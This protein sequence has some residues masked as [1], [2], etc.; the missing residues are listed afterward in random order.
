MITTT[1]KLERMSTHSP[2]CAS[3]LPHHAADKSIAQISSYFSTTWHATPAH[4]TSTRF[5]HT[6]GRGTAAQRGDEY[7]IV[8]VMGMNEWCEKAEKGNRLML[9]ATT[10]R[11]LASPRPRPHRLHLHRR[12]PL[13][14]NAS[15]SWEKHEMWANFF[16]LNATEKQTTFL[17]LCKLIITATQNTLIFSSLC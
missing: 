11:P 17:T 7:G 1:W 9:K 10:A 14:A 15:S 16:F 8:E 2:S 3:Y 6:R 5:S 4:R 12:V 13:P